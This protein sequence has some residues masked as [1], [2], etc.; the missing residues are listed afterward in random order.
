[1]HNPNHNF[2]MHNVKDNV[3]ITKLQNQLNFLGSFF[4]GMNFSLEMFSMIDFLFD[5]VL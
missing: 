1:M 2:Y 5:N 3:T 4:F